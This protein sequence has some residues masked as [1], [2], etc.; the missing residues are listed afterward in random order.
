MK[1]KIY[2]STGAFVGK[3]NGY[4]NSIVNKVYKELDCDGVELLIFPAWY[5]DFYG[6]IKESS[7]YGIPFPVVHF[8]KWIG[9]NLAENTKESVEK[10]R[11]DFLLNAEAA[12]EL[13]AEKAVLHLWGGTRSDMSI[14][15]ALSLLPEFYGICEKYG[16]DLLIENIPAKYNG[17]L[18]D[19]E[20][21]D[22]AY[23]KARFIYDTRFG[24]FHGESRAIFASRFWERVDHIHISSYNGQMKEWGLLRPI[25]QPGEGLIDFDSLIADMPPYDGSVTLESPALSPDGYIDIGKLNRSLG[26]LRRKFS[27]KETLDA[28]ARRK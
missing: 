14:D 3:A 28:L 7:S 24:E 27:E 20:K 5:D 21:I 6:I 12:Y 26:Y 13:G 18:C 19:F 22:K 11:H 15:D 8:D 23:P 1:N 16:I 9:I 4:D 10:A 25:L 17:P 2:I